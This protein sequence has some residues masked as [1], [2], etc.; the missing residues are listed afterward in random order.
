MPCYPRLPVSHS[1]QS[2]QSPHPPH[3][4]R[5]PLACRP[6]PLRRTPHHGAGAS[7]HGAA[8]SPHHAASPG[9][10]AGGL[11]AAWQLPPQ[12]RSL[13][14]VPPPMP[15]SPTQARE[16]QQRLLQYLPGG[17]G[18]PDGGAAPDGGTAIGCESVGARSGGGGGGLGGAGSG[19]A[20]AR[21]SGYGGGLDGAGDGFASAHGS[22]GGGVGGGGGNGTGRGGGGTSVG[23][24]AAAS[25]ATAGWPHARDGAPEVLPFGGGGGNSG[26]SGRFGTYP[27]AS[28]LVAMGQAPVFNGANM[29][30][31]SGSHFPRE[32]SGVHCEQSGD[33]HFD[34]GG[35]AAAGRLLDHQPGVG[36]DGDNGRADNNHGGDE[37]E[38]EVLPAT[39]SDTEG[40]G[41]L[42]GII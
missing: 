22:G 29:N 19:F 27:A 24:A 15:Y 38:D 20:S 37:D 8:A 35:G 7:A 31:A 6:S 2:E 21:G 17:S 10:G 41:D 32:S 25:R 3:S 9:R 40:G 34:H 4:S 36:G 42:P 13:A 16:Q 26:V 23:A 1:P 30:Y 12:G 39:P 14:P 28:A 18:A 5:D 33:A 11:A